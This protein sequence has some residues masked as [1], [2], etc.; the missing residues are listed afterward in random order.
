MVAQALHWFDRERFYA[1][2]RRVAAPDAV[3]AAW[4]YRLR[5]AGD[6]V[7]D[8]A[9]ARFYREV[10]GPWWP[11]ERELVDTDY[12]TIEFPFAE[13]PAPRF[14]MIAEWT[15][16]QLLGYLRTWSATSRY[17][18]AR[19]HDPVV[20]LGQQLAAAWGNRESRRIVWSLAVRAGRT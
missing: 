5:G 17:V 7:I 20:P 4:T 2:A 14:Q 3:L 15:L 19:G 10:L 8:G 12:R 9:L 6:A 1:E 13:L 11:P 18:Q 16:E